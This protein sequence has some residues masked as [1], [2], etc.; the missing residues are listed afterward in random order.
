MNKKIIARTAILIGM[1]G[2]AGDSAPFLLD[3]TDP[4]ITAPITYNSSWVG[5]AGFLG[6]DGFLS[7]LFISLKLNSP[8][9]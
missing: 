7:L 8:I 6:W 9:L 3:T 1:M 2:W 5:G 4:L